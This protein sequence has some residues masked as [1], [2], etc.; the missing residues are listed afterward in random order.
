[1]SDFLTDD[2]QRPQQPASSLPPNKT[3]IKEIIYPY[4]HFLLLI[5][6]MALGRWEEDEE[7]PH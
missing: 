2:L 1:M 7:G 6:Q 5:Q 4:Q 3:T